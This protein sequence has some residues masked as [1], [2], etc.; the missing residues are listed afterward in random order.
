M[1]MLEVPTTLKIN[2]KQGTVGKFEQS[3]KKLEIM[4]L[5]TE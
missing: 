4:N 2:L 3:P 1:A 5:K